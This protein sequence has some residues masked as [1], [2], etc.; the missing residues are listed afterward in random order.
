MSNG[1]QLSLGPLS[2]ESERERAAVTRERSHARELDRLF[3][4]E[5]LA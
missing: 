2:K 1:V 4:K 5:C 3:R